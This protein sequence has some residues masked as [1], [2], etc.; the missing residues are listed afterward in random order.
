MIEQRADDPGGGLPLGFGEGTLEEN[1]GCVLVLVAGSE[2]APHA[3]PVQSVR[4]KKGTGADPDQA[5]FSRRLQPDLVEPGGHVVRH[6]SDSELPEALRP[7]HRRLPR[8]PHS[9]YGG[10]YVLGLGKA[11]PARSNLG[12]QAAHLR[13]SSG[14]VESFQDIG[15]NGPSP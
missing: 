12:Y 10:A 5:Q 2:L 8:R 14:V 1:V 7:G 6:R 4:Q 15:E 11:R 3:Q 13:V 9:G